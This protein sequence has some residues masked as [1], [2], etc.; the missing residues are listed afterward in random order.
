MD[1]GFPKHQEAA[2]DAYFKMRNDDAMRNEIN[3]LRKELEL[4]RKVV[5]AARGMKQHG[6]DYK[7]GTHAGFLWEALAAYDESRKGET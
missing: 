5:E 2:A 7:N 3:T 6:T 4:A 1:S